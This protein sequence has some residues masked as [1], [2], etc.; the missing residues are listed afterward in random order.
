MESIS[1]YKALAALRP[2]V[3]P[4]VLSRATFAGSGSYAAHWNG[5]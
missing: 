4:F 1:T 2:N 3:R 5:K